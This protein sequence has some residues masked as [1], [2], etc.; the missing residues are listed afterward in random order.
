MI[1][2]VREWEAVAPHDNG[3]FILEKNIDGNGGPDGD[4]RSV[5]PPSSY[6]VADTWYKLQWKIRFS[7]SPTTMNGKHWLYVN[8]DN[9]SEAT[10][11]VESGDWQQTTA[12]MGNSII[13][14]GYADTA[15]S[16]AS[17]I[18]Q[19][20]KFEYADTFDDTWGD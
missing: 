17:I 12:N 8:G 3:A 6:L 5:Y 11:T 7:T 9:A 16:T 19:F 2:N 1:W 18:M 13:L 15:H 14:G 20:A 4:T 10:P